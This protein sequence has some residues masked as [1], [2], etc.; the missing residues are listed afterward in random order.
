MDRSCTWWIQPISIGA[1]D[2]G[3]IVPEHLLIDRLQ[4]FKK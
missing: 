1:A 3:K 2:W 4:Y